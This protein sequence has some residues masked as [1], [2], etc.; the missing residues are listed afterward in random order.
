MFGMKKANF[1]LL[2][3]YQNII[4]YFLLYKYAILYYTGTYIKAKQKCYLRSK[5]YLVQFYGSF[6]TYIYIYIYIYTCINYILNNIYLYFGF[7]LQTY[8]EI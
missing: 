8:P 5:P 4:S 2:F 1:V 3:P 7:Q 6:I